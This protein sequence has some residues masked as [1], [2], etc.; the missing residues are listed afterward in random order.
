MK[1]N[2]ETTEIRPIEMRTIGVNI[3]GMSPLI[4]HRFSAKARQQLLFPP[5]RKNMAERATTMKHDPLLEYREALYKNSNPKE[6][7][8]FHMPVGMIH[9]ALASAALDIP[10]ATKAAVERLTNVIR[11][12]NLFGVPYLGMDMVRSSDQARTPDVRTRPKFK[13]WAFTVN[14]RYKTDPLTDT[15]ILNL[16]AAAGEIVGLGDWRTQ[17]GGAGAWGNFR[18]ASADDDEFLDIVATEGRKPQKA[19]F[20]NPQEYDEET[21]ELLAWFN[22]EKAK[23]RQ[24]ASESVITPLKRKR[25]VA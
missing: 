20:E 7:T 19:A 4:M 6:P 23:R 8:L 5:P 9:G 22:A 2:E 11:Q 17:K 18:L 12:I 21:T 1:K 3:V 13:R 15:Q 10:G 14:I 16:L 24:P 25:A